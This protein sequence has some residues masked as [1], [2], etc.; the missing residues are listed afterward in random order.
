[1]PEISFTDTDIPEVIH[2]RKPNPFEPVVKQLIANQGKAKSFTMPHKTAE[3]E[4]AVNSAIAQLQSAGRDLN[5]TVRKR[6]TV[7]KNVATVTVWA[8][9]KIVR[10]RK[11][12]PAPVI[13]D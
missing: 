13:E 6:M 8:V 3:D 10:K 2:E 5:V 1:M 9:E 4:K 12:D 11:S 7:E